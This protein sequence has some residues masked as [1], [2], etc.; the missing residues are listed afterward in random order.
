MTSKVPE[1]I[2]RRQTP[3]TMIKEL[4]RLDMDIDS[5]FPMPNGA[6]KLVLT[7]KLCF[8]YA[9]SQRWKKQLVI[10]HYSK[11]PP[12]IATRLADNWYR[13][14]ICIPLPQATKLLEKALHGL[15]FL[16]TKR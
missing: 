1:L 5:T 15:W 12:V 2:L 9:E 3:Y 16:E 13:N 7:G 4:A 10:A 6:S 11:N 8:D 14:E